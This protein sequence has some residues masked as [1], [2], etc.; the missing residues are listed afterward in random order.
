MSRSSTAESTWTPRPFSR[1]EIGSVLHP[2]PFTV[3]LDEPLG[4]ALDAVRRT[5]PAPLGTEDDVSHGP[6][7]GTAEVVNLDDY[8][9][10]PSRRTMIFR[11][12]EVQKPTSLFRTAASWEGE[13]LRVGSRSFVA[14]LHPDS[15]PGAEEITTFEFSEIDRSMSP[16][17]KPGAIFRWHVGDFTTEKRQVIKGS[18]VVFRRLPAWSRQ[19]DVAASRAAEETALLLGWDHAGEETG[20]G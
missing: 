15:D 6:K 13:V 18:V 4:A 5:A 8:R 1:S 14:R 16:F 11:L 20:T 9:Q 7:P 12:D 2:D 3:A 10:E 19:R 17:V